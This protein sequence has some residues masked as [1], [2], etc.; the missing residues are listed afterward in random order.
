MQAKR[1]SVKIYVDGA[2]PSERVIPVFHR[3]IREKVL[4]ELAID[5]ADY[6][7]VHHGP[8]VVLVGHAFDY[9]FEDSEGRQGLSYARKRDAPPPEERL[10]DAV[11]R[12]LSGAR[13]LEQDPALVG[14]RFRAD[15]LRVTLPD[16]LNAPREGAGFETLKT[17][18]SPIVGRLSNGGSASVEELGTSRDPVSAS[19]KIAGGP[20]SVAE[21]LTRLG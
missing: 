8:G 12:A 2:L 19:V 5:V 3:W 13:R 11:R 4:D 9:F 1:I 10:L 16:R 14:L 17:E 7:H 6:G 18:L 21:L 20:A 15:E